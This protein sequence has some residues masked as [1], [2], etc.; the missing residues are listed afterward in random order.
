MVE[1]VNCPGGFSLRFPIWDPEIFGPGVVGTSGVEKILGG[2]FALEIAL[3]SISEADTD[4]CDGPG[5]Y[6]V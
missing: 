1:L 4:T 5:V 2:S 3:D 6:A